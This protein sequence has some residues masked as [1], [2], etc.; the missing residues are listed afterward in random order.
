MLASGQRKQARE[1]WQKLEP[2]LGRFLR[3]QLAVN[4]IVGM[5]LGVGYWLIG[6]PFPTLLAVS[7]A[8]VAAIPF[9]GMIIAVIIPIV[10]GLATG[11]H[12][13]LA[14][15]LYTLVVM[16]V[17]AIWIKPRLF[18][19]RWDNPILTLILLVGLSEAF[20]LPGIVLAPAISVVLQIIWGQLL[21]QRTL[22]QEQMKVVDFKQRQ[23]TVLADIRALEEPP[24]PQITSTMERLAKLID[25]AE[26]I[27]R[28]AQKEPPTNE[29][30]PGIP[31]SKEG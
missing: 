20:G 13:T 2:E 25:K 30:L 12:Y 16:V 5:L 17:F 9:I 4:V 6:S 26:P 10:V 28:E 7:G 23:E 29:A 3:R 27:L 8:F 18:D 22:P 1:I 14:I 11:M 19:H 21:T 31:A 24:P 15:I